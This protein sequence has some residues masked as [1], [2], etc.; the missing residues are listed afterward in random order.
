VEESFISRLR[1]G[2]HFIFAGR[3]LQLVRVHQMVAHVR[4][5]KKGNATVPVWDGG[6]LPLSSL[7]ADAVQEELRRADDYLAAG[8]NGMEGQPPLSDELTAVLPALKIQGSWSHIPRPGE[9]LIEKILT[10]DGT[11]WFLFPFGGR[12]AHEGVGALLAHRLARRR[13]LTLTVFVNDYGIQLF[14]ATPLE[15]SRE[16]WQEI[17]SP[18]NL[19][20]D[21]N[22]CLNAGEMARRQFREI[23]R[24][25]GLIFQG[26]PGAGKPVRQVQA[27]SSLFFEVFNKYEPQH[28]L[29]EQARKE[30]LN[31]Q[32]EF[33]RLKVVLEKAKQSRLIIKHPSRLTPM[34]FPL[35]AELVRGQVSSESWAERVRRMAGELEAVA[36]QEHLTESVP[37]MR[38]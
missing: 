26:Y 3:L 6:R 33:A 25:A 9:L 20:E 34:S 8:E 13:P 5:A 27:S 22:A 14:P 2:G 32:L 15:I 10:R 23:A 37:Q 24:I 1:P 12:L 36:S 28:L 17:L 19:L 16:E 29:L 21:L 11:H 7:L 18:E 4:P 38:K 31:Q 30:V 35:W